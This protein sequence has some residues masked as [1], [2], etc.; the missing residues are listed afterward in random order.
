MSFE[1]E[2]PHPAL[3]NLSLH[4]KGKHSEAVEAAA[5]VAAAG[6]G[7]T[8]SLQD[9]SSAPGSSNILA[10]AKIMEAYLKEGKLNPQLE[11]T[12]R[13]FL[14]VFAAWIIE[15]D[16]PFTTGE[17][18]GL[19][20]LFEYMHVK[21]ML[22]SDTAVR[23]AVAHIFTHLHGE[24]VKELA[25]RAACSACYLYFCADGPHSLVCQ[26]EDRV[27]YGYMDDST[28]GLHFRRHNCIV[29]R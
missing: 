13:G 9:R 3:G 15:D 20:R 28:D 18:P 17:L 21:F 12:Q 5:A 24:V 27:L 8:A 10:S 6:E 23:N 22:P 14:Q 19:G 29:H 26:V 4:T 2:K 16:L 25:V 7:G 11:P 1:D